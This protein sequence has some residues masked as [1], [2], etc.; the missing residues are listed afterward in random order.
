[1]DIQERYNSLILK[2][3]NH[4]R[5]LT[6]ITSDEKK[7]LIAALVEKKLLKEALCLI[8]HALKPD[9]DFREPILNLLKS[10]LHFEFKIFTLNCARIHIIKEHQI[11]GIRLPFEF[12]QVLKNLLQEPNWE[13]R[14]WTLRVIDEC[15]GQSII[16]KDDLKKIKPTFMF[17]NHHK[18]NCFEIINM[19]MKR[20]SPNE[21]R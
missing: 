4:E 17:F 14:E 10:D 21:R 16:F 1:M 9:P 12:I 15:G 7:A 20:W 18:K 6:P 5:G 8:E 11:A 19:L 13:L 3:K 2:L